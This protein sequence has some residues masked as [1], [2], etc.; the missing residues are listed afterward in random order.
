MASGSVFSGTLQT[1][2]STKLKDLSKQHS[3]FQKQHAILLSTAKEER[4]PLRRLTKIVDD[5]KSCLGVKTTSSKADNGRAGR[6][7]NGGTRNSRL[8]TDLMNVDRFLDQARFD[9]SVSPDILRQWEEKLTRHVTVQATKLQYASLYGRLVT[10]WLSSEQTT[11]TAGDVEMSDS[12]EE[13]PSVKKLEARREWESSVFEPAPVELPAL[14]TYLER[15]FITEKK[16]VASALSD[17]RKKVQYFESILTTSSQFSNYT[18]Q[19]VIKSLQASDLLSNEKREALGDFLS[20]EVILAEIADVLNMRMEA[21][22]R[23]SW[24]D[25]VLVE[26]RRQ[27]NGQF[28]IHM[29]EDILQ[30]IFLHYIGVKWSVFFKSALLTLRDSTET[31]RSNRPD[32]PKS[33]R[34]RRDYFLGSQGQKVRGSLD[35]KRSR[36]QRKHYFTKHL[37]DYAE[38]HIQHNEGEEEA[39]F[40]DFVLEQPQ[41]RA[42]KTAATSAYPMQAPGGGLF[43]STPRPPL[44]AQMTAAPMMMA[45]RAAAVEEE[46]ED[47]DVGYSLFDDDELGADHYQSD[48][49]GEPTKNPMAAKQSLLHIL[50]TEVI[51]NTHLYGEIAC[52]RTM[53]ESWNP[54]LPHDTVLKVLEFFGVSNR[55]KEFFKTYLEAP[56]KFADD[57]EA[58][59]P[60]RRRR[61]T[62]G[63][64]ALS[65]VFGEVVFFCLDYAVN[66]DTGGALLHRLYD[67]IW[68][69][70]RD[71]ETCAVAWASVQMFAKVTGTQ[72]DAVKSGSIRVGREGEL[73]IDDRL[74]KGDIRWGFLRLNPTNGRFDIDRRMVEAHVKELRQQL[75]GKSKSVIDW[76]QAWNLYATTFFST[77]FGRAA[78]CFG[79]EHIDTMLATHRQIQESVFDGG[80]VAQY[81]KQMMKERFGVSDLPDGFLYFPVELGGLELKSPF[82]DLLLIRDSINNNPYNL[83]DDFEENEK[84]DYAEAR[85]RFDK[86]DLERARRRSG[87]AGFQP[88]DADVFFDMAEFTKYREAFAG[89][90]KADLRSIYVELLERP[91]EEHVDPSMQVMQALQE[92]KQGNLRGILS[93]WHNM[94]AYWKWIAQMYGPDMIPRFGGFNIVDPGWLPIGM[95]SQFRQRRT[96][97]Q[98]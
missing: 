46:C 97:W 18:L 93:N 82:V 31:W 17:L 63:S 2:T 69:W 27:I 44:P 74:P 19:W 53:F 55:W 66:Q 32:I 43:G 89:T 3:T 62:P 58:T 59:Q 54:L 14:E 40:A 11:A 24:G 77:N 70:N 4:D 28:Q 5:T 64:H 57:D 87:L 22:D 78:N 86:G 76:I 37:L 56:L 67:D 16:K 23:W 34:L 26:Q 96:K 51:L 73:D 35:H 47:D 7:I 9:P 21:L 92:L 98:G 49:D 94:E 45:S 68:F 81:L 75:Q 15:L 13:F 12:F 52:F 83:L 33:D 65:D 60:R 90:G 30:A 42:K 38:Q 41:K 8:E 29:H 84:D 39:D 80:N 61:G 48:D 10:E 85:H 72:I 71:Y 95:V 91:R 6:V 88:E 36:I 50:A 20:N 79:R 25:H 1:I